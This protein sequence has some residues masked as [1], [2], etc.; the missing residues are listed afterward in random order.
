MVVMRVSALENIPEVTTPDDS[1]SP[2]RHVLYNPPKKKSFLFKVQIKLDG[3][4][5][6]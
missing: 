6:D 3:L 1:S 5:V 2:E 4:V